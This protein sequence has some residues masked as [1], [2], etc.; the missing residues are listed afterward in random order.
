[1]KHRDDEEIRTEEVS[2]T[3]SSQDEQT[4]GSRRTGDPYRNH[5]R[6]GKQRVACHNRR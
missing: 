5:S 2:Q 4:V 6:R 3:E 1:M